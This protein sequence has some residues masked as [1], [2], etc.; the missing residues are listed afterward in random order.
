MKTNRKAC[1][2]VYEARCNSYTEACREYFIWTHCKC[3]NQLQLMR[4]QTLWNKYNC[5]FLCHEHSSD[6]IMEVIVSSTPKNAKGHIDNSENYRGIAQSSDLGTQ[7]L[8]SKSSF[9]NCSTYYFKERFQ[10]WFEVFVG[11]RLQKFQKQVTSCHIAIIHETLCYA[12]KLITLCQTRRG[13]QK[14]SMS[15]TSSMM[16]ISCWHLGNIVT[17]DLKYDTGIA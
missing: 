1:T 16:N 8:F 15:V 2:Y 6:Y 17:T 12:D 5:D 13:L 3:T 7:N 4:N 10:M 9:L 14:L 11:K